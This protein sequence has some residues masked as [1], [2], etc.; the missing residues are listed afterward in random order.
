M[1]KLAG[2]INEEEESTSPYKILSKTS[3]EAYGKKYDAYEVE[4][5][6]QKY[7]TSNG[8]TFQLKTIGFSTFPQEDTPEFKYFYYITTLVFDENGEDLKGD[9]S[10]LG[11]PG[12]SFGGTYIPNRSIS[13]AKRWL[14]KNGDKIMG[15]KGYQYKS[16]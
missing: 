12:E 9:I 7:T 10:R 6:N 8:L 11:I 16:T 14:E 4:L 15:G 2:L 5:S 3:S 13:K 1:Q